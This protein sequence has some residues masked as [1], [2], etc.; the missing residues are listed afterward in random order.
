MLSSF[1]ATAFLTAGLLLGLPL[2]L[3]AQVVKTRAQ[4]SSSSRS[5][6]ASAD[7]VRPRIGDLPPES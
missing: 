5:I 3:V 6:R 2:L 7:V 1:L 4:K